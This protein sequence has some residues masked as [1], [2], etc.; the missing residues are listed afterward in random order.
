MMFF[1]TKYKNVVLYSRLNLW[2]KGGN[3]MNYK[4]TPT[5]YEDMRTLVSVTESIF[6]TVMFLSQLEIENKKGTTEYRCG[7]ERLKSSLGMEPVIY[8]RI[9]TSVLKLIAA[10]DY[11]QSNLHASSIS[12]EEILL[13]G[14]DSDMIL[15]RILI[16]LFADISVE[17]GVKEIVNS[18][19]TDDDDPFLNFVFSSLESVGIS[20]ASDVKLKLSAQQDYNTFALSILKKQTASSQNKDIRSHLIMAKYRYSFMYQEIEEL[21][22]RE[23]FEIP[24]HAYLQALCLGQLQGRSDKRIYFQIHKMMFDIACIHM[25][26]LLKYSDDMLKDPVKKTEAVLL[27]GRLRASLL[28]LDESGITAANEVF[29]IL[30]EQSDGGEVVEMITNAYR[31]H[32]KDKS[33]PLTLSFYQKKK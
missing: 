6:D 14:S 10:V 12:T 26:S 9:G 3:I 20:Y 33:I 27:V 21:L 19:K 22:V 28:L 13:K 5:D 1:L 2:L 11:I 7:L 25:E 30:M 32:K 17:Q 24:S 29:H 18:E 4:L 23:N 16:R 15:M 8:G 31:Q